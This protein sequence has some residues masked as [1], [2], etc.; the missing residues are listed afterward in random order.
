ME[1]ENNLKQ[2]NELVAKKRAIAAFNTFVGDRVLVVGINN[3]QQLF[4]KITPPKKRALSTILSS[5]LYK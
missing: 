4:G 5:L 1:L 2:G 3:H